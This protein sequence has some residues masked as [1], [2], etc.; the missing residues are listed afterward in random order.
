MAIKRAHI[1][2]PE[3]LVQ[4][5]DALV[6][7]RKRSKFITEAAKKELSRLRLLRALDKA[8][9]SWSNRDHPELARKGGAY[10]WVRALRNGCKG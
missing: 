2:I 4:S 3:D 7:K 5:I 1:V 8:K 10:K 9:G 6:G